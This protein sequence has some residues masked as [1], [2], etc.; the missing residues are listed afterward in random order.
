[1][2]ANGISTLA[3]KQLRQEKKLEIAEA[4]RQGKTVAVDGTISGS[5]DDTKPYYRV[6][7]TLDINLLPTKYSGNTV[8]DNAN[9]G[10]LQA[11][12]PWT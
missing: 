12:R 1:M 6:L 7:N 11:G 9:V 8:V 4:K 2:A 3:T 5:V 10:G